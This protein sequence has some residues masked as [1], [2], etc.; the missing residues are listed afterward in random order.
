MER[1][2]RKLER[3]GRQQ[4]MEWRGRT[5]MEVISQEE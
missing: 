1:K 3:I 2:S 5:I 4:G